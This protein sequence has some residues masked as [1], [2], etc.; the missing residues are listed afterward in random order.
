MPGIAYSQGFCASNGMNSATQTDTSATTAVQTQPIVRALGHAGSRSHRDR[1]RRG[2]DSAC[3]NSA[4]KISEIAARPTPNTTIRAAQILHGA[5]RRRRARPA[6]RRKCRANISEN[7]SRNGYTYSS[8]TNTSIRLST[9]GLVVFD[10]EMPAPERDARSTGAR[11][12]GNTPRTSARRAWPAACRRSNSAHGP[13]EITISVTANA[14]E[15]STKLS[16]RVG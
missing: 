8:T 2:C 4:M 11:S 9:I 3:R 12:A 1:F 15:A 13:R 14:K 6:S 7:I 10:V 16:S 5:D